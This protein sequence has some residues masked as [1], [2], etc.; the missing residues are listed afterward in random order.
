MWGGGVAAPAARKGYEVGIRMAV[1]E[2]FGIGKAIVR[3][4]RS[5][6]RVV[7]F[8]YRDLIYSLTITCVIESRLSPS[9]RE[10][11]IFN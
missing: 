7:P 2:M 10:F 11:R 6:F 8:S 5:S 3:I 9:D 1:C 4:K